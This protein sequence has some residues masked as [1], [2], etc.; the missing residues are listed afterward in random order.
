MACVAEDHPGGAQL[1]SV[2]R[3][4]RPVAVHPAAPFSNVSVKLAAAGRTTIVICALAG[5]PSESEI[6]AVIRCVPTLSTVEIEA[7]LPIAPSRS[8]DHAMPA[9]RSPS[10]A[11]PAAPLNVSVCP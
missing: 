2:A 3:C 10:S 9:E 4:Q 1:E 8:E 5:A 11:S 7:P 6:D